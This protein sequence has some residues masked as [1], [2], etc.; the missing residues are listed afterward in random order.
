[1]KNKQLLYLFFCN[2]GIFF[3]GTGLLPILPLY[4]AKF[5]ASV[6]G[7]GLYLRVTLF[8]FCWSLQAKMPRRA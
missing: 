3:I 6:T 4:A 5:G 7:I 8:F 1:M 2:F